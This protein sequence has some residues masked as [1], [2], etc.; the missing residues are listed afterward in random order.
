MNQTGLRW[1]SQ[2]L[3]PAD[4]ALNYLLGLALLISPAL[5]G[6]L[7]ALRPELPGWLYRGLGLGFLAFALWQSLA[8]RKAQLSR[9]DLVFASALALG[10]VLALSAALLAPHFDLNPVARAVLWIGDLYMLGL[11]A[12]YAWLSLRYPPRARS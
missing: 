3:F 7:L 4:A 9:A 5:W 8:L 10:P 12:W 2:R 11:G 6:R 1:T